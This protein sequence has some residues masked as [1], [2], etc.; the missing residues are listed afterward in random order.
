[1][2]FDHE[3]MCAQVRTLREIVL[4]VDL[5]EHGPSERI[6]DETLRASRLSVR[7]AIDNRMRT[8]KGEVEVLGQLH[9]Q[10][11][12]RASDLL[13]W[14]NDNSRSMEYTQQFHQEISLINHPIKEIPRQ[15]EVGRR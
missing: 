1:M 5:E 13:L 2:V 4:E 6:G 7:H 11:P 10:V 14:P 15:Q 3:P 12:H 8:W 9:W